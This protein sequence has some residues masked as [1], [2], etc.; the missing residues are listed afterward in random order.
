[1][2]QKCL[3]SS[4]CQHHYGASFSLL[5]PRVHRVCHQEPTSTSPFDKHNS[6]PYSARAE[7][8]D[9]LCAQRQNQA[10][11]YY[12]NHTNCNSNSQ[13]AVTPKPKPGP[14]HSTIMETNTNPQ[15]PNKWQAASGWAA[16]HDRHRVLLA[17]QGT[18]LE[19]WFTEA[20]V[21]N[22][23]KIHRREANVQGA[24][25]RAAAGT[26]SRQRPAAQGSL[27][28]FIWGRTQL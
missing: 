18:S 23:L 22:F 28:V 12:G 10:Q 21:S 3:S 2:L 25:S 7:I 9:G 8:Q 14:P 15:A 24:E 19:T 4:P 26:G 13:T 20:K 17:H 27:R 11:F 16:S 6:A 5:D 1:M